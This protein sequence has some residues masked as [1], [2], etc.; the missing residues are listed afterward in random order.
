MKLSLALLL[1]ATIFTSC[2]ENSDKQK[3]IPL[4]GT[5]QL[6]SA[7]ST[8]RD[9]TYSTFNPNNK[10]IKIITPTHFA[11]FNHDLTQGK[12]STTATF[13]GGGGEYTLVDSVYTEHLQYFNLREWEDHKFQFVV[14]IQNDTLT[15]SGVEK[16]E[17]LG[18]DRVIVEKYVRVKQ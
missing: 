3:P 15:Q 7:T 1:T 6:I 10:M 4:V 8:E 18:I 16:L 5:W 14:K 17:K 11:F 2:G 12:D 13:A 9:S